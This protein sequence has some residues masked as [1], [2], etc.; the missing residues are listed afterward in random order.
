MNFVVIESIKNYLLIIKKIKRI[1]MTKSKQ[2][3]R[4]G[5]YVLKPDEIRRLIDLTPGYRDRLILRLLAYG[6]LRRGEISALDA[7]MVDRKAKRLHVRGKGNK[8]RFVPLQP[9]L[10]NDLVH[11][12]GKST[13]KV[14]P[15]KFRPGAGLLPQQINKIVAAAGIRAGIKNPN[16]SRKKLN[17]H[18]LRHS[19]A[20][21]LKDLGLP[22]ETIKNILGHESIK[23]TMDVYGQESV[24]DIE[25]K[26][27]ELIFC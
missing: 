3:L 16:P 17:P 27:N 7:D 23:T 2:Q 19:Y 12:I 4:P 24:D 20:R 22:M 15:G 13:G 9:D 1:T 26:F 11:F 8:V 10:F 21:R 6:G 18:I 5:Q 14:F 25:K